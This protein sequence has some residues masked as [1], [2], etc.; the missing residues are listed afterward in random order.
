V[1]LFSSTVNADPR[2]LCKFSSVVRN[3]SDCHRD[4]LNYTR[5]TNEANDNSDGNPVN[6][7]DSTGMNHCI[8]TL[9]DT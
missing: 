8:L 6:N 3:N 2:D 5:D 1:R 4:S 7:D 9:Y